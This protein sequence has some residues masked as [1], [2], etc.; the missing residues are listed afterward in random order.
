MKVVVGNQRTKQTNLADL[1]FLLN[2]A[3]VSKNW[4][5]MFLKKQ[6]CI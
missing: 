4:C 1:Q 6:P 2:Y 5:R 3:L